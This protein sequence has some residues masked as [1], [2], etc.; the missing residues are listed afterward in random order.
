MN[1]CLHLMFDDLHRLMHVCVFF[2][3][4]LE[5][6]LSLHCVVALQLDYGVMHKHSFTQDLRLHTACGIGHKKTL[7]M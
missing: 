1:D 6:A 2:K 5:F 3:D 7:D 4:A